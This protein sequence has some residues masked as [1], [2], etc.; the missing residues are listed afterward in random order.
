MM[1]KEKRVEFLVE[2]IGFRAKNKD[3]RTKTANFSIEA[4]TSRASR[5]QFV[6]T[7]PGSFALFQQ[8]A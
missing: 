1:K 7:E 5:S 6:S 8:T 3:S 4:E 2:L